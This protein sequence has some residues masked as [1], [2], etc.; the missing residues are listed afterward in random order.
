MHKKCL[1][2]TCP[3]GFPNTF[4]SHLLNWIEYLHLSPEDSHHQVGVLIAQQDNGSPVSLA[5]NRSIIN[6]LRITLSGTIFRSGQNTHKNETFKNLL[7]RQCFLV[8]MHALNICIS[9]RHLVFFLLLM[10]IMCIWSVGGTR[11]DEYMYAPRWCIRPWIYTIVAEK[12]K[13]SFPSKANSYH[14]YQVGKSV[15]QGDEDVQDGK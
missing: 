11:D 2:L 12:R 13:K 9:W 15:K 8:V 6:F 14:L 1:P 10:L 4:K 5:F 3:S 7:I